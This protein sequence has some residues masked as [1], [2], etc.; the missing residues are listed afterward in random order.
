MWSHS[1]GWVIIP[2]SELVKSDLVHGNG[3]RSYFSTS[4]EGDTRVSFGSKFAEM[5]GK[6]TSTST[7]S[8]KLNWKIHFK[9]T[10][11]KGPQIKCH[12]KQE[13]IKPRRWEICPSSWNYIHN[14]SPKGKIFFSLLSFLFSPGSFSIEIRCS[15]YKTLT[16]CCQHSFPFFTETRC[17]NP[18]QADKYLYTWL[19]D[20]IAFCKGD[21]VGVTLNAV[22]QY[23]GFFFLCYPILC[24]SQHPHLN[25]NMS[26]MLGC[27]QRDW[28]G[29]EGEAA[30]CNTTH[31]TLAEWRR[32]LLLSAFYVGRLFY[33]KIWKAVF[34]PRHS[35]LLSAAC[36][37]TAVPALPCNRAE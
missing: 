32:C 16:C 3:V 5:S 25:K 17:W 19:P 4:P 26:S 21:G 14:W 13:A 36:V 10:V 12:Q 22:P 30:R 2:H 23:M 11:S 7:S 37:S 1:T 31:A 24:S 18:L 27:P 20:L 8:Q 6:H 28:S 29:A 33:S 35:R 34:H 9:L 15:E